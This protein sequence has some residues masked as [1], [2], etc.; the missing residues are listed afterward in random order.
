LTRLDCDGL[1]E[2]HAT[3]G[4]L[5]GGRARSQ[6]VAAARAVSG[7]RVVRRAAEHLG[8]LASPCPG[9]AQR[10]TSRPLG[11]GLAMTDV[12]VVA[13]VRVHRETLSTALNDA[14]NLRVVGTAATVAEALPR[15]RELGPDV[16]VLDASTPEEIDLPSPMRAEPEVKLVAVGVAEHEAV[17][18][19]E[20]GVSGCVS[21][22]ASVDELV[23]A[24]ASVARGEIVT[25]PQVQARLLS[26]IRRLAAEAPDAAEEDRLTPRQAEVIGLVA[27]GLS[28]KQ[29]ARRLSIQ[30]QTVKNHMHHV[31]LRLGVHGRGEAA[32]Q[33]RRRGRR[34]PNQ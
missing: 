27:E 20:A 10:E 13:P 23:A 19:M 28:N 7:P 29:I 9:R 14:E 22:E 15:L 25:S 32:A 26:R 12:F 8:G 2:G 33:L 17:D 24:V 1:I 31:L 4:G 16:A 3:E 11:A 6:I 18:W 5:P 34:S 30:E 21:P